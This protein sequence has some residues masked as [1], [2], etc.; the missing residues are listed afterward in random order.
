M[1]RLD[2]LQL[3]KYH[4]PVQNWLENDDKDTWQRN[5]KQVGEGWYY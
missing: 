5:R 2:L 3:N 1:N 4:P